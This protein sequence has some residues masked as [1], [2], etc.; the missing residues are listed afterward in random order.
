MVS[1]L[2]TGI[3]DTLP[4]LDSLLDGTLN[5][6]TCAT[7]GGQVTADVPIWINL[8]PHGLSPLFYMPLDYL[9]LEYFDPTLLSAPGEADR[10]FYSYNE[11]ARQVRA[12]IPIHRLRINA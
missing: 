6:T 1:V 11:L 4:K 3:I 7:C 2:C 8:E 10:I 9:E 5:T 12:R